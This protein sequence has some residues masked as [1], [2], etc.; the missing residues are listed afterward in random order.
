MANYQH[1]RFFV[2]GAEGGSVA[3]VDVGGHRCYLHTSSS[4]LL[5]ALL[6]YWSADRDA[7]F[8]S[9]LFRL[10]ECFQGETTQ[11]QKAELK[12]DTHHLT[13]GQIGCHSQ[14]RSSDHRAIR[15]YG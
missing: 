8:F 4:S 9:D 6:S 14:Q 7:L 1:P 13:A 2:G 12:L 15:C 3:L 10:V 11:L 5:L